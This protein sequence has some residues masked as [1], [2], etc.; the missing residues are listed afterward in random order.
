VLLGTRF[1]SSFYVD[2]DELAHQLFGRMSKDSVSIADLG[3]KACTGT[4]VWNR[5]K[6]HMRDGP[7]PDALSLIWGNGI[8]QYNFRGLGN[9]EGR[10]THAV[11]DAK[12]AGIVTRGDAL[13]VKRMTAKE[14]IRRLVA[15]RV[16]KDLAASK[17][18][19]FAENHVNVLLAEANAEIE[20]DAVL[21]LLNSSLFD[22]VF[23]SLNG[24]TQVSATELAMLP[25]KLGVELQAI[26]AQVRKLTVSNGANAEARARIEQLVSQLYG[27]DEAE[28]EGLQDAYSAAS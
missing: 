8:R 12:T 6:Q 20:L 9:R 28:F 23:R 27:L 2:A 18:G 15:C 21:G 7:S 5:L 1:S 22:Y 17:S 13:L 19:Y 24:N 11:L 10:A 4:V 26:A 14:E 3:I 16:P 25:V